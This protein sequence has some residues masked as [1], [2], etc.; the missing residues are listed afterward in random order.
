MKKIIFILISILTISCNKEE[1]VAPT[2]MTA[3]NLV[4]GMDYSNPTDIDSKLGNPNVLIN[5][6]F[7]IYPNPTIESV[8][9]SAKEIISD[10]WLVPGKPEK[11]HQDIN[12]SSILNSNLYSE[13]LIMSGSKLSFNKLSLQSY[14]LNIGKLEKGYY[15]VFVKIGGVIYWGH[16]YKCEENRSYEEQLTEIID[17]WK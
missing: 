5:N 10:I 12:F 2:D 11:I 1:T 15:R 4:T 17:F 13:E 14:S 16:I 6:K 9:I 8:T 7:F 3:L